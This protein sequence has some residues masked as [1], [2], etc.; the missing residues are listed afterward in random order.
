[1]VT[2]VFRVAVPIGLRKTFDYLPPADDIGS[3]EPGSRVLVPFGR[4]KRVG[5]LIGSA[6]VPDELPL[7]ALKAID[8]VLDPEPLLGPTDLKLLE[9][10][11]AYY[12]HPPAEVIASAFPVL[13]RKGNA[14]APRT[15]H[16]WRATPTG[17]ATGLP[18]LQGAPRQQELLQL[19]HNAPNGLGEDRLAEMMPGWRATARALLGKGLV[20]TLD[21]APDIPVVPC[22]G[23]ASAPTPPYS[24]NDAQRDAVD[25]VTAKLDGYA[26][27]LLQ[28]VTGSG[29]TEVYLQLARKTIDSGRQALVLL[30]EIS[31]TPQLEA[32]F[33]Q[34]FAEPVAVF[35]SRLS[36]GQ[37][38]E[39]WLSFR[40]GTSR[41]LLG[42]RSAVFTPMKQPGLIVVDEEHDSSYKQQEGFRFS[43]RDV[44]V[45]R[46]QVL[47]I[48]ILLGSATPSLE[49]LANVER[50]RYRALLLPERAGGAADPIF[51]V[52]DLRGQ[53]LRE[54]VSNA[55]L[56]AV[57]RTL[58]QGGQ[59]LLFLNRRGYAPTL[60]CHACGWVAS[61][62]SCDARL[63]VHLRNEALR[64]HYCGHACRLPDACPACNAVDLRPLGLG[65]QR[66]EAVLGE[67]FPGRRVI[68]VDRDSTSRA[69]ALEQTLDEVRDGK[70]DILLGTQMLA[71]GHHFPNV[72]L[73]GILDV[74]A[75]L[76]ATDFRAAERAAQLIVQVAGRAGRATRPGT[77]VLQTRHPDHPLLRTLIEQGY[78]GFA[79][80]ALAERR[81]AQLPPGSHLAIVRADATDERIPREVLEALAAELAGLNAPDML[82]LGPAPAPMLRQARRF[83]YQL[84]LQSTNRRTLHAAAE[85]VAERIGELDR[86]RVRCSL[87]IDPIDCF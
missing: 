45:R 50:S 36:E 83:R 81:A 29:K 39:A 15:V 69:G 30:P 26:S 85:R 24:L 43:A 5:Y 77:V 54:G 9:W 64:C 67:R 32:R 20:E 71:K 21:V 18:S 60:I 61:C 31:L 2:R 23:S 86:R 42:T 12:H 52:L 68:R 44:A 65:T 78:P 75:M 76:F 17:L 25:A 8:R 3:L 46:A 48:P 16:L 59:A 82:V 55:L 53:R 27:F 56:E 41:V 84:A 6:S 80:A 66:L 87:D 38:L 28:G 49:T 73:V 33:R 11:A 35:H 51:R 72:M 4:G 7:G 14:V 1:M 40:A 74:D 57:Q 58:D 13:L 10:A 79:V 63:V 19:F 70:A 37:R 47:G 62:P 34:R 22:S